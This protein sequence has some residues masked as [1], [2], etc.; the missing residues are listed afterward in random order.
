MSVYVRFNNVFNVY[1]DDD[2]DIVEDLPL[3]TYSIEFDPKN[4]FSLTQIK[5]FERQDR[6]YGDVEE[7]ADRVINTANQRSKS[8][9][10][11]LTGTKGSGKTMLARL[12]SV[13]ARER[14]NM[15]T[16]IVSTA[17]TQHTSMSDGGMDM[18][19][20]QFVKF[21]QRIDQPFL[22]LF[23]EFEKMY[24]SSSAQQGMLSVFDGTF[25][26]KALF[27]LTCN[28]S[29]RLDSNMINRPGRLYYRFDYTTLDREFVR[30]YAS[31]NLVNQEYVP[32]LV[33]LCLTFETMNFDILQTIVEECNRYNQSPVEVVKYLNAKPTDNHRMM[34]QEFDGI[35]YSEPERVNIVARKTLSGSIWSGDTLYFSPRGVE[36]DHIDKVV[37]GIHNPRQSSSLSC[38]DSD[39]DI[40]FVPAEDVKFVDETTGEVVLVNTDGFTAVITPKAPSF[41]YT[42]LL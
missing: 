7:R 11:L 40:V 24:S 23:D 20:D 35:V 13:E 12:L 14:H 31:E 1:G 28:D 39:G 17:F 32:S 42:H 5:N 30:E 9:G 3:G 8:T 27:V 18:I 41:A 6:Y 15:S 16:L 21:L 37:N 2:I 29:W 4:G 38:V 26:N 22:L 19:R 34:K 36:T 25:T 33:K 10:V